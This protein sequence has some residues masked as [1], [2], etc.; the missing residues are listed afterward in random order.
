MQGYVGSRYGKKSQ[1]LQEITAAGAFG[2][3]MG[4]GAAHL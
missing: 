4:G 2:P 3:L 1:T